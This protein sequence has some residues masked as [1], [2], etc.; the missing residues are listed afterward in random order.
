MARL[1]FDAGLVSI[2]TPVY[3]SERFIKD[4][5]ESVLTQ[6]Y[7]NWE[8]YLIDDCSSDQSVAIIRQY[9]AQDDRIHLIEH[10]DNRGAAVAR[11]N[12]IIAAKGQY[13]A[14]VDS[15]DYWEQDKLAKQ[16]NFMRDHDYAFTYTNFRLVNEAG[17]V[18]KEA[19]PLPN[20][21]GYT[22]LLK[23]TAIACSSVII[24]RY[25][26]G[27][28]RMPL[29]R[30]GQDSATWLMLMRTR[31]G[32]KAYG[33]DETLHNYRQVAGSVSSS[34]VAALRRTWYT[35]RH[36]EKLPLGKTLYYFVHYVLAAARRRL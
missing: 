9:M 27:D 10:S 16:I 14:F 19:V 30:R 12:G 3:N 8:M 29:V 25:I 6:S 21:L 2:I 31:K 24:D 33:L 17:E 1:T 7:E 22:D 36:L 20:C 26:V 34:R 18:I 35:Y 23:N 28:F 15:D 13:I 32:L 11:N 5:I 4:T